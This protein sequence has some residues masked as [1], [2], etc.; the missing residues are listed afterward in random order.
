MAR[1]AFRL[2]VRPDRI[3]EYEEAHRRVWPELL[4]LFKDLGIAQYSIFRRG[5]DLFF[6]MQVDDFEL[7]WSEIDKNP[8]NQ[9]WQK[10][11]KPLFEPVQDLEPGERFPMMREIFY[12]E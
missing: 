3:Q 5:V 10:E 7:A 8:I 9:H 1:I 6:Y 2:R 12:L 4:Q 11:M